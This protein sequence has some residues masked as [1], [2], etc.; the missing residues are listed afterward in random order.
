MAAP[1]TVYD[2]KPSDLTAQMQAL[3]SAGYQSI[4]CQQLADYLANVQDIPA[5]SVLISFDDG[6]L[7]FQEI[8]RPILDQF[9][10]KAVLFVNPGSVG[11]KN[12]LSWDQLKALAQAGHEINS[13]TVTHMN[14][15]KKPKSL[16]TE[17]F[18]KQITAEIRNSYEQIRDHLGTAPVG[19][20]YPFGNYDEFVM[21][22]THEVGHRLGFTIDPGAVDNKSNPWMLPRKMVVNGTALKTFQR[23]LATEPLHLT[24][25]QPPRGV[26][27]TSRQYRLSATVLDQD[28]AN[29]VNAEGGHGAKA[30]YDPATGQIVVTSRLN[31]GANLVRLFSTG[32]P[33]REAAWIVVCDVTD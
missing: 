23:N 33:R 8:A 11:G 10:F 12:F 29:A 31:K 18:H 13:H 9:G 7:S 21:R 20:A 3:K 30:R 28:A 6:R 1:K 15:T 25:I 2:V 27:L 32:T 26:R 4:S 24:N 16:T 5:K 19:L 17:Q 22:T 14:L